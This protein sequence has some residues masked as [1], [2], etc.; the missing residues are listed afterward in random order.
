VVEKAARLAAAVWGKERQWEEAA[1]ADVR[2]EGVGGRGGTRATRWLGAAVVGAWRPR[3]G[4]REREAGQAR[5]WAGPASAVGRER[6]RQTSKAKTVFSF[7][8]QNYLNSP[9]NSNFN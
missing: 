8:I 5:S 2:A 6:E 1:K 4:A 9:K 3:G 7:S